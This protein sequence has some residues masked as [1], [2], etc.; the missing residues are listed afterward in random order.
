MDMKNFKLKAIGAMVV[1]VI[2]GGTMLLV[3]SLVTNENNANSAFKITTS[4]PRIVSNVF[5]VT[6][7]TT[8]Y[9]TIQA[10][11]GII[12]A[13]IADTE[14]LRERGLSGRASLGSDQGMLFIFNQPSMVGF[15]MKEMN[16]PLDMVWIDN[17]KTVIGVADNISPDTY[18]KNFSPSGSVLYV[19][20]INAGSAK[21]FGIATGTH[22]YFSSPPAQN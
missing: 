7:S 3:A 10:P 16:F 12:H 8:T 17:Y 20:E 13:S 9:S 22:L 14:A 19:L 21:K 4:T 15:W 2:F 11:K 1:L 18:P 6:M 5:K